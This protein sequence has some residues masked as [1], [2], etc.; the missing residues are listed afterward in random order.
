MITGLRSP[1]LRVSSRVGDTLRYLSA[2]LNVSIDEV[3]A[4]LL[5]AVLSDE[6]REELRGYLHDAQIPR[7]PERADM[8]YHVGEN[9]LYIRQLSRLWRK[10]AGVVVSRLLAAIQDQNVREQIAEDVRLIVKGHED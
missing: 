2:I 1:K 5:A 6:V 4:Y 10:P 7:S 9:Y 3:L 8:H